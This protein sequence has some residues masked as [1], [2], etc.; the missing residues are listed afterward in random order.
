M[1]LVQRILKALGALVAFGVYVW[2]TA[3]RLAPRVKR[4]K[5]ARRARRPAR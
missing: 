3:V 5:T 2:F 1:T 4:R